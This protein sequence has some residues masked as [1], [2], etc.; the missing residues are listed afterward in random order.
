MS[1]WWNVWSIRVVL[2]IRLAS[3]APQPKGSSQ[4]KV[5]LTNTTSLTVETCDIVTF[6]VEGLVIE[7][8]HFLEIIKQHTNGEII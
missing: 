1:L 3:K 4:L 7:E 2:R 8:V 6:V 5:E